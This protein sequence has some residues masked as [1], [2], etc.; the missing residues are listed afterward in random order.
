MAKLQ[1]DGKD[2]ADIDDEWV[3]DMLSFFAAVKSRL[4]SFQ[5]Q[6]TAPPQPIFQPHR[7]APTW[8]QAYE[9]GE[10]VFSIQWQ[11]ERSEGE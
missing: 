1:I 5:I 6:P 8:R 10:V 3:P 9:V 4:D 2:I 7:V 11:R